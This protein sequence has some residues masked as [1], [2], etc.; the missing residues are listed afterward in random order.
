MKPVQGQNKKRGPERSERRRVAEA[1][2]LSRSMMYRCLLLAEIPEA[3]FE[4]LLERRPAP[5]TTQLV[6]IARV[7]QGK[8]PSKTRAR[9]YSSC[10]HCGGDL[11]TGG[12]A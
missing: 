8:P 7:L 12:A 9:R 5:T 2:G 6:E 4:V 10:Q 1:A 3:M 11:T